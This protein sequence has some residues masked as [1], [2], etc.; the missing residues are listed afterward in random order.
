[1]STESRSS[2]HRNH[3]GFGCGVPSAPVVV[4]QINRSSRSRCR[5]RCPK[6][7]SGIV[8]RSS[9]LPAELVQPVVVDAEM[10]PDLVD[11]SGADL[12]HH[13]FLGVTDLTDCPAI[14]DDSIRQHHRVITGP[15]GQRD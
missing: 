4:N 9:V 8:M 7:V 10:M 6:S 2:S 5:T 1:M 11:D 15:L 3:T 14:Y 13:V 12:V